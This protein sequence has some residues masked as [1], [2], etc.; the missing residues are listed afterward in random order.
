[1]PLPLTTRRGDT[2]WYDLDRGAVMVLDRRRY[3]RERDFVPCRT[4]DEVAHAI[5]AM[6]VQGGSPL[7]YVGGY[8]LAVAARADE[9]AAPD[10]LRQVL[11]EVADELVSTRQ[12][13]DDIHVVLTWSLAAAVV[14][15]YTS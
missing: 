13:A 15:F 4:V 3:P 12:T 2:L 11:H 14:E 10:D 9:H 5:T 1:M 7:A 8:G 6:I